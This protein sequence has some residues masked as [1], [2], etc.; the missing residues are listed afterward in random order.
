MRP[1]SSP[2]RPLAASMCCFAQLTGFWTATAG[3]APKTMESGD[4]VSIA[5]A[6]SL[7]LEL[8]GVH[9]SRRACLI[10]SVAP[11]WL[12]PC[13]HKWH[14]GVFCTATLYCPCSEWSDN[15]L[16]YYVNTFSTLRPCIHSSIG[17]SCVCSRRSLTIPLSRMVLL[18]TASDRFARAKIMVNVRRSGPV[19]SILSQ[20]R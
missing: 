6:V 7:R 9:R 19:G 20:Y 1:V 11:S 18:L 13:P 10:R 17:R 2:W 4:P 3:V 16:H 12:L 14:W 15:A 5:L 8:S